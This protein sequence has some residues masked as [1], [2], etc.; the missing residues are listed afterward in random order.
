[1]NPYQFTARAALLLAAT[2][3]NAE[4]ADI[5]IRLVKMTLKGVR[6]RKLKK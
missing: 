1:M 6:A 3:S 5:R 2:I 4:Q